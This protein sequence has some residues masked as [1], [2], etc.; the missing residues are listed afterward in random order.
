MSNINTSSLTLT[1]EFNTFES[2]LKF[3]IM[4]KIIPVL[5]MCFVS[6]FAVAGVTSPTSSTIAN[7]ND[8]LKINWDNNDFASIND[9]VY[10]YYKKIGLDWTYSDYKTLTSANSLSWSIPSH[11][12]G[13]YQVYVKNTATNEVLES[14]TF[15]I[16]SSNPGTV[17]MSFSSSNLSGGDV[18]S[19]GLNSQNV[20][21]GSYRV[22]Y[23]IDK[24][25]WYYININSA[26]SASSVQWTVPHINNSNVYVRTTHSSQSFFTEDTVSITSAAEG[27][28]SITSPLTTD[29]LQKGSHQATWTSSNIPQGISF[30]Y[31]FFV[32]GSW[33]GGGG[34]TGNSVSSP[35]NFTVPGKLSGPARVIIAS[36]SA[37]ISDT[38]NFNIKSDVQ[39]FVRINSPKNGDEIIAGSNVTVE[40]E[41]NLESSDGG[42][43]EL[44]VSYDGG[45][46]YKLLN[47]GGISTGTNTILGYSVAGS[48]SQYLSSYQ[49]CAVF[50]VQV[51]LFADTAGCITISPEPNSILES[52]EGNPLVYPNPFDDI[53]TVSESSISTVTVF[54]ALGHL[55]YEGNGNTINLQ[56]LSSGIYVAKGYDKSGKQLFTQRLLKR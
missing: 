54:S 51:G 49:G 39:G 20:S 35:L 31:Q 19:I 26:I 37:P 5:I 33:S 36:S 3:L 41:T 42:Q 32:D 7:A 44:F 15:Q 45:V 25:K 38:L 56:N 30:T 18:F 24:I 9:G 34:V 10:L 52:S 27:T 22:Q 2:Q 14:D 6:Q 23:S 46:N 11:F 40:Y 21:T 47:D 55:V 4:K 29:T 43:V 1:E 50:K 8:T 13:S 17:S 12:S 48:S 28:I 53:I 16:Q